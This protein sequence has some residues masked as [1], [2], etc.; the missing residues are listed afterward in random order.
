MAL[1][2]AFR[3]TRARERG[4][5]GDSVD[6][7]MQQLEFWKLVIMDNANVLEQL[8]ALL[9]KNDIRYCVIGGVAVNAYVEPVVTLDLDLV[10]V[11][12][13]IEQAEFLFSQTFQVKRF[14]H[15]LN[16]SQPNS[17]IR[18]QVQTDS[19]YS[20][21]V[22]RAAPKTVLGLTLPVAQPADVLQGKIWAAQDPSRRRSKYFKDLTDISRLL[23]KFP[24]LRLRVP[25]EILDVLDSRGVA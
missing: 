8:V 25:K 3:C 16:L 7:A 9:K 2:S 21:F 20:D 4:I 19:R 5:E 1:V 24:E 23:D 14:P 11:L 17:D 13:Q 6:R 12:D 15:S 10:I 22:P 18:I